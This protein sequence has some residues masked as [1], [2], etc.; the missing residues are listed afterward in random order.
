METTESIKKKSFPVYLHL[1]QKEEGIKSAGIRKEKRPVLRQL[2]IKNCLEDY[3]FNTVEK[4]P[5][6][7]KEHILV[8]MKSRQETEVCVRNHWVA[9]K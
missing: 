9:D 4:N 8:L 5:N 3:W 6:P 1:F 2:L 7:P